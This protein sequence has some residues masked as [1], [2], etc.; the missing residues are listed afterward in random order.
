MF[1]ARSVSGLVALSVLAGCA[2]TTPSLTQPPAPIATIVVPPSP[3]TP[4]VVA[5]T[6]VPVVAPTPAVIPATPLPPRNAAAGRALLMKLLPPK[7]ADRAGWGNDIFNAF[8]A[9][10]LPY[11]ASHFCAAMAVLEQESSWQA[12]PVVSGLDK[13]VWREIETRAG[14]YGVPLFAVKT[15]LMV[16]S[17]DGRSYKT[18]IDSLRTE[19]ELDVLYD[20]MASQIPLM[21]EKI[22]GHS[23]IRTGGPMQVSFAFAEEYVRQRPYPYTYKGNLRR[24]VFSRRGG[25]YFGIAILLDFPTDYSEM[26]YRFADFNAG[27]Y[28]SRNAAF[29][30]AVAFLAGKNL[31]FDGDLLRYQ[32]GQPSNQPSSTQQAL[33]TLSSRL[34]LRV[35]EINRDLR[36]EKQYGFAQTA[37]YQRV[38]ALVERSSGR[39]WPREMYP[40]IQLQSQKITRKLTTEW[41]AQRVS[42]RYQACLARQN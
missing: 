28:S 24:E 12:D 4:V 34:G 19:R 33:L 25:L 1:C 27:R 37:L 29:Q 5:P 39:A 31:A 8:Q 26:R 22:G 41:F 17:P 11:D 20:D 10:Q 32:D 7:L 30:A 42:G 36:T 3:V 16:P 21:R 14:K 13:I 18:R 15:A 40:R 9:L 2:T 38:F 23:P 35:D 6:P